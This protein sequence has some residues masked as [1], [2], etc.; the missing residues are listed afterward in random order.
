MKITFNLQEGFRGDTVAIFNKDEKIFEAEDVTTRTQI[1]FAKSFE[2]EFDEK[3]P[4][5]KIEI[6]TRD[7]RDEK[8]IETD[9]DAHVGISVS[10]QNDII[11]KRSEEP[12]M[13]M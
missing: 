7:I 3:N 9:A 12:F 1:G 6:P 4:L 10:E 5:I 13:Y 8:K 2:A 11:W